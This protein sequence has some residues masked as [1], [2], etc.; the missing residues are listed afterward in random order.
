MEIKDKVIKYG[1]DINTD[2]IIAG[3]YTKTLSDEDLAAHAMED[4]DPD[5]IKS[6]RCFH[7]SCWQLFRLRLLP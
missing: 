4:L 2:L 5:F 3:K 6:K 7:S 1:N